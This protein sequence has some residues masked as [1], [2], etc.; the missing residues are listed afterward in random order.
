MEFNAPTRQ[1][2]IYTRGFSGHKPLIP[3]DFQQ[4]ESAAKNKLSSRAFAYI[5]GGAG[6]ES[7]QEANRKAWNKYPIIPRMLKDVSQRKLSVDFLGNSYPLPLF[8]CPIGVLELAHPAADLD[9]ARACKNLGIPMMVSNQ[10]SHSLEEIAKVL[11]G[12][13]WFFQLYVSRSDEL[14]INFIRRAEQAGARGIVITLDTTMLGWRYRDLN[15]GY[16][17]FL[18][19]KGIAQ[20]TSDPIFNKL[21]GEIAADHSKKDINLQSIA[22][23]VQLAKRL[24]GR[25]F[26][27]L[28][29]HAL[30]TVRLF[31]QIYSRPNLSW[32]TIAWIKSSTSLPIL[33]K[34]IQ[35]P[36]DAL[37]AMELGIDAI[38]VSNHGGRQVDGAIGSLDALVGISKVVN[39]KIPIL[40]DSGIRCGADLVKSLALGANMA[41]I[42]R[43]YAYALALEGARGV[44][45]VIH[46]LAA[47]LELTMALAGSENIAD[48]KGILNIP[49]Q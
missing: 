46:N 27:N 7:T 29:G 36:D 33:L 42:G 4:L 25:F 40:F 10:A 49:S 21:I 43:P 16:L 19:G 20:Y 2:N 48:L 45:E 17:P 13:H 37:K 34:G 14:V 1:K 28:R 9:V 32:E 11:A 39:N 8:L 18:E 12:S 38:Y 24:P 30:D 5:A 23:L 35:H 3:I 31:T 44:E 26:E 15:L 22:N 47:D 6:L 41:G